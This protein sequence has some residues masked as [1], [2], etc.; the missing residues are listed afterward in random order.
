LGLLKA[1]EI[2]SPRRL[3]EIAEAWRPWRSYAAM[4]LWQSLRKE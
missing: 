3:E 2:S 1:A 4:Y